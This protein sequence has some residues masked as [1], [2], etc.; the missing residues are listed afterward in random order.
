VVVYLRAVPAVALLALLWAPVREARAT[1]PTVDCPSPRRS[2]AVAPIRVARDLDPRKVALGRRLFFDKRLS[3]DETLACA[4]CHDL[5]KGGADGLPKAI[6]IGRREGTRNTPSVLNAALNFRQFWDGRARTLEHQALLP[7]ETPYEMGANLSSVIARLNGDRELVET[8]RAVYGTGPTK[9]A[10]ADAV[11]AFERSLPR[12]SR[13]DRW[14]CG[15]DGALD[16]WEKYGYEVFSSYGCV[17]CH[18][19]A[20]IG[21][22]MFQRVG[23]MT[24]EAETDAA[25][26]LGRYSVTRRKKDRGLFKVPSLRNVASTAPY[27]HDG[28]IGDLRS[29]IAIMG[30]YQLRIELSAVEIEAI[31]AFLH[32]LSQ[33]P[34]SAP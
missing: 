4:T 25:E 34:E 13:F 5:A 27:M 20:A 21:G 3:G 10:M 28:R 7:V 23:A 14:L 22:N 11:A 30:L 8:F 12:P 1:E 19:G 26:D 29:V 15:D 33:L 32:T 2:E 24:Q 31:A 16:D 17:A 6:G 18:Q 9:E